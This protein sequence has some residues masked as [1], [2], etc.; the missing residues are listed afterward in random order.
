MNLPNKLTILRIVLV[1]PLIVLFSLS[2]WSLNTKND[3]L[4]FIFL[5][6]AGGL[7]VISMITDFLDG[8]L[9][10]KK[11]QITTFG[12]LFDPLADKI[13]INVTLIFL[14]MFH[15]SSFI[16]VILFIIRDL[17]V[18]GSRNIIAK[19]NL[20]FEANIFGKLKTIFQT[21]A[22]I[23]LIFASPF[24]DRTSWWQMLL[25]NV[26]MIIASLMSYFS[27]IIYFKKIIPY[28]KGDK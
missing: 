16:F 17:V 11:N 26:P 8:Y 19:H 1:V 20:K 5:N 24:V 23:I 13:T 25:I 4:F 7:F 27:G 12:K 2:Y 22:I 3:Y 28:I 14:A 10:R 15:Y 9:A 6:V 21:I 18:D